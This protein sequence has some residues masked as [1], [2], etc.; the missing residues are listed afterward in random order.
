MKVG[1]VSE[2]LV[3]GGVYLIA[4]ANPVLG[5]VCL[6]GGVLGGMI[7]YLYG[8]TVHQSV[9]KRRAEIYEISKGL[10]GKLLQAINDIGEISKNFDKTIH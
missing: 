6:G 9:E 7:A 5:G 10:L 8:V 3:L 4:H 1:L 2:S